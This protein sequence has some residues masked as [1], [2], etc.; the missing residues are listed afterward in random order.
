[1]DEIEIEK[2][3]SINSVSL[4]LGVT[5]TILAMF[6]PL[7]SLATYCPLC[8]KAFTSKRKLEKVMTVMIGIFVLIMLVVYIITVIQNFNDISDSI[9]NSS[10]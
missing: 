3:E 4:I 9:L 7:F 5:S 8:Y 6:I 10:I 2:E 1:M